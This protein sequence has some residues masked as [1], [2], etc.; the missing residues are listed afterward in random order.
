[1]L[2]ANGD[3]GLTKLS[4]VIDNCSP[5]GDVRLLQSA[6]RRKIRMASTASQ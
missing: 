5:M 4:V 3:V 2:W 1:M 6:Q